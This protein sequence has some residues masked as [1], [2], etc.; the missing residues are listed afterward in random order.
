MSP[1]NANGL[2][3]AL[4][5]LSVYAGWL[6][7]EWLRLKKRPCSCGSPYPYGCIVIAKDGWPLE[8]VKGR[9]NRLRKLLHA[10]HLECPE[11]YRRRTGVRVDTLPSNGGHYPPL[12]A[13][14]EF[15]CY[16]KN[17]EK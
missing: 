12:D 1:Q 16:T 5:S 8:L 17:E 4:L 15:Q 10:S 2:L 3:L 14:G 13:A 6:L 9:K 11:C 7:S